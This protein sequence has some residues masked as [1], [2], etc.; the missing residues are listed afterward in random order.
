[1]R[2]FAES[3][4]LKLIICEV[5]LMCEKDDF[6]S[7]YALQH[8]TNDNLEE[9][10]GLKLVNY[11]YQLNDLRVDGLGFDEDTKSFVIIEYKNEENDRVLKQGKGYYDN[12]QNNPC[13]YIKE[14]NDAFGTDYGEDY[15]DFEKTKVM[16]IGPKFTP[17]QIEK[18]KNP[19]YPFELYTISL[20]KC[21]EK[22]G[23]VSYKG[24]NID[25]NKKLKNID[26][27]DLKLTKDTLLEDKSKEV[28]ELYEDFERRLTEEFKEAKIEYLVDAVSIK[29]H[30]NFICNVNVKK[31]IR[32]YFY[33][34]KLNEINKQLDKDN[35]LKENIRNIAY[36]TT[37]G[38]LAYFELTLTPSEIEYAIKRI[39]QIANAKRRRNK[40]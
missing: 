16:I 40:K 13:E 35:C 27:D 18:S 11:E 15:F 31:S 7:E 23:C 5:I 12:L 33:T 17:E 19:D 32:I 3:F 20:Y 30:N 22:R 37:G 9:L 1:M 10:F 25:F 28:K 8:L 6:D 39:K 14:Y 26:L 29:A 4:D 24:V 38:P 21:D 36:L 2:G 34:H